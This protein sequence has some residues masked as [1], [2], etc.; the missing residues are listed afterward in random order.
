MRPIKY[1]PTYSE[2]QQSVSVAIC[3]RAIYYFFNYRGNG[4]GFRRVQWI[5]SLKNIQTLILF[6]HIRRK[7]STAG[8]RPPQGPILRHLH[9]SY[10]RDLD[11]IVLTLR[12]SIRGRHS[13][14][15]WPHSLGYF[16]S[17]YAYQGR[18]YIRAFCARTLCPVDI[19]ARWTPS[20]S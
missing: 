5:Y 3:T 16:I 14:S 8:N 20:E 13:S 1:L 2:A 18:I 12:L 10:S 4:N 9:P 17:V 11:Q 15:F 7:T 19:T 6:Q